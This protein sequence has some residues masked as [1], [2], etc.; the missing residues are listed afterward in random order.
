[1]N[2]SKVW[3]V[4]LLAL[5]S[6]VQA[7]TPPGLE[8]LTLTPLVNGLQQ[9]LFVT[10]APGDSE[11]LFVLEQ[12]GRV[13]VVQ[14]GELLAEPLLDIGG[15]ITCCGERGLLG[16]AFHPNYSENGYFFVNYTDSNGTTQIVRYKAT[17]NVADPDSAKT[18]LSVQQPHSNHNGG[19]IAFGPDGY[20][21]IG[22]GDGGSGGDPD[23]NG[24]NLDSLLGK[25]LRLDVDNG[26]PYAIPEGNPFVSEN[27]RGEIW[28]YGWRNPWRFSFDK[29]TGDMW[30]G[31]VG[32]E[33]IEEISFQAA[34]QSGGNY[35]WRL[36]EGL[37]CYDPGSDCNDGSLVLP[38]LEYPHSEGASVTGGYRYRGSA[39]P[40]L[41]G[42]YIYGDFTNGKLWLASEQEGVW[43]AALWQDS[44]MNISSFGEDAN[45]EL[46][47]VDYNGA[48]YQLTKE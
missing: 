17:N 40:E 28:S 2:F 36:M 35:G 11:R 25:M 12:V 33:Q 3:M 45:G 23:N 37:H 46:Y 20:L 18:I 16:L 32:Q 4:S 8:D 31:D 26:D 27:A 38:V 30:V 44:N 15:L 42:I 1:M 6:C 48:I 13:R 7:N 39:I 29:G 22:M 21:Y 9:P 34:G 41:Q 47:V 43:Q 10:H 14:A 19:M 24:Q 5:V